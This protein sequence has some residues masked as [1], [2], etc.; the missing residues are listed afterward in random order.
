MSH[1]PKRAHT[2]PWADISHAYGPATEIPD[3]LRRMYGGEDDA[4]FEFWNLVMH[5]GT[6]YPAT[7]AVIPVFLDWLADPEAPQRQ[8]VWDFLREAARHRP[9]DA[10]P[11][12]FYLDIYKTEYRQIVL[13]VLGAIRQG[14]PFYL[15]QAQDG[16]EVDRAGAYSLLGELPEALLE[17]L[18]L[19]TERATSEQTPEL[20]KTAFEALGQLGDTAPEPQRETLLNHLLGLMANEAMPLDLRSAAAMTTAQIAP[21]RLPEWTPGLFT[22]LVSQD[23]QHFERQGLGYWFFHLSTALEQRHDLLRLLLENLLSHPL[24]GVRLGATNEIQSL[25]ENWRTERAWAGK[26]LT[27]RLSVE[28]EFSVRQHLIQKLGEMGKEGRQ[29]VPLLL[30]EAE[31]GD[32][33]TKRLATIALLRLRQPEATALAATLLEQQPPEDLR[34]LFWALRDLEHVPAELTRP[35]LSVMRRIREAGLPG[36][37]EDFGSPAHEKAKLWATLV[38]LTASLNGH[39]IEVEAELLATLKATAHWQVLDPCAQQL[40]RR[41]VG[42]AVPTLLAR[43][44]DISPNAPHS[45]QAIVEALIQI[46]GPA[47]LE[48][49]QKQGLPRLNPDFMREAEVA[50]SRAV[51]LLGEQQALPPSQSLLPEVEALRLEVQ[52]WQREGSPETGLLALLKRVEQ[53]ERG[54]WE[55]LDTLLPHVQ[56]GTEAAGRLVPLLQRLER[57]GGGQPIW[58]RLPLADALLR[59]TGDRAEFERVANE[60]LDWQ[61]ITISPAYETVMG[62][63]N[64]DL[65]LIRILPRLADDP[66]CQ[67]GVRGLDTIWQDEQLQA[68]AREKMRALASV[69]SESSSNG[70]F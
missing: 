51:R 1:L 66:V 6:L 54:Q 37:P 50:Y 7:V 32:L 31:Q 10:T 30:Q 39:Q 28:A 25:A 33:E 12:A 47:A 42:K 36:D 52:R 41:R 67:L 26:T 35:A 64:A 65:Y 62:L 9:E 15:Q 24:A 69:R 34:Q 27:E 23:P 11:D 43:V 58:Y 63:K 44:H 40:G 3:L 48:G 8:P 2:I 59:L 60:F 21:T 70:S 46:G 18:P 45:Y 49:L 4:W 55:M 17:S 53:A 19:L 22:A 56:A 13:D 5:Q 68:W 38:W 29:A 20:Q 57:E 61:P 16:T 14:L